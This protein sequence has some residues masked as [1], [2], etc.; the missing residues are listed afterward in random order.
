M[1]YLEELLGEVGIFMEALCGTAEGDLESVRVDDAELLVHDDLNTNKYRKSLE[2]SKCQA[3]PA[4][5][6]YQ[7][8]LC[9]FASKTS[10]LRS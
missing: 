5:I 3:K 8:L 4:C 6:L 7:S 10:T 9:I 1:A 2:L